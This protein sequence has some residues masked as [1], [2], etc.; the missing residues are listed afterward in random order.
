MN[1]DAGFT[2]QDFDADTAPDLSAGPWPGKFGK[3]EVRRGRPCV[4][5]PRVRQP[6]ADQ[7]RAARVD[8]ANR[9]S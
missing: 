4:A 2:G 1:K 3:A 7:P 9:E 8:R 5:E 6:D